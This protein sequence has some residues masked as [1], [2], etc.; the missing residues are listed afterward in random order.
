MKVITIYGLALGPLLA[1][2]LREH[3][4]EIVKA[5]KR[6]LNPMELA[7][8]TSVLALASARRVKPSITLDEIEQVVDVENAGEIFA[9]CWG[10]TVP[11][12]KP[13]EAPAVESPSS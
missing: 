11:E 4:A 7:E 5:Q 1:A 6:E 3:K 8:L 13:G 12:S 9:A 10:I 2:T